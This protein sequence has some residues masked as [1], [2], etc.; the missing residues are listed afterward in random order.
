MDPAG[1]LSKMAAVDYVFLGES[2]R[3]FC[4]FSLWVKQGAEGPPPDNVQGIAFRQGPG[5]V[6]RKP[7]FE[8]DLGKLPMAAW[9][10]VNPRD[11]PDE[12]T[13]IFVSGFPAPPMMLSRGCPVQCAY[14]GS[15][16]VMGEKVRYRPATSILEEINFLEQNYGIRNFTFVDDNYTMSRTRALELFE[17]LAK[18]P[19]RI[20]FTFPNGLRPRTLDAEL[21][22]A[23]AK[24]G[25]YALALGIESGS[26]ETLK[27]MRKKQTVSEIRETVELVRRETKI[28]VTGFFILGYPGETLE[29]VRNTIRF[30]TELPIHHPHFCVFEPIP[31]TR[32]YEEL[33]EQGLIPPEGLEPEQLTF[34][35]P[36][37]ALP[38]LPGR[39]LV[40][41]HQWA[42]L[43]FYLKPWRIWN[44]LTELK[45]SGHI[46]VILRRMIKL[47]G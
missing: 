35:K 23:M 13:G 32:V 6:I 10:L 43:R 1:T 31:G 15:R 29:D 41:L 21:L 36:S 40:R 14:C 9:D 45:S 24:A 5:A 11:Y 3:S 42:Y 30:A 27:R 4:A 44:L 12:A 16:Y 26:D 22:R 17:A 34:D 7:V 47:L 18:R 8:E 37:L 20:A 39:E 28:R 25:C 46:W 38:G 33:K 2:E 19:K